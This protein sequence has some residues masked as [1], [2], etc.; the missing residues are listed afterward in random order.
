LISE[1]EY[2][3][4]NDEMYGNPGKAINVRY[5][6]YTGENESYEEYYEN[7]LSNIEETMNMGAIALYSLEND[8]IETS[9]ANSTRQKMMSFINI[10]WFIAP[11]AIF[12][13]SG[14]VA[15]EFSTKTI[16]LLLIRP[17]KRW[18]ILLSKYICLFMLVLGMIVASLGVYLIGSGISMGFS[19]LSQPHLYIED[20]TVHAVNF[21]VWLTGRILFAS[22]PVFCLIT[23]TFMLSSVTKGSAVSLIIGVLT[24]F[25][26]IFVLF[27]YGYFE[28][29][30]MLTY[31]P[32]SYFSMWSYVFDDV[33]FLEGSAGS[34]FSYINDAD[35]L[36]GIIILAGITAL[37][38]AA[39]FTDF[40][41]KDIK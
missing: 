5:D 14:M 32:F 16:N 13:A 40:N 26:S 10:F 35:I 19:D 36:Y 41:K 31:L 25:S 2:N 12:F 11:L 24:L 9:V 8:V 30:D 21:V 7:S 23:I 3:N 18:K 39:A 29:T 33:V 20:G 15:K 1:E 38:L 17:V 22:L 34:I 37:S 27:F 28:N 6:G 4:P